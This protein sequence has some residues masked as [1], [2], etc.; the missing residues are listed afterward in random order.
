MHTGIFIS[1]KSAHYQ[2]VQTLVSWRELVLNILALLKR[3]ENY[4]VSYLAFLY[5]VQF[6]QKQVGIIKEHEGP[7]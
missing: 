4:Q 3:Q 6:Y 1:C 5:F 7:A 2:P